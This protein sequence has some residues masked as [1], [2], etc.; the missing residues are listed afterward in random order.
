MSYSKFYDEI[1][2]IK[3]KDLLS[4]ILGIFKNGEYEFCY[5]DIVKSAGRSSPTIAVAYVMTLEALKELYPD[6][7]AL[8]GSIQV[9]FKDSLK[10]DMTGVIANV[11]SQITG[12]TSK[13]GF[14]GLDGNFAR[15]SL[16]FYDSDI[17][18]SVRFTRLEDF[19]SVDV[20]YD[21]SSITEDPLVYPLMQKVIHGNFTSEEFNKFKKLWQ[22]GIEKIFKN[23]EAVIS[24]KSNG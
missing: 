14:K 13:S 16:M 2:T 15:H 10:D 6:G 9:E 4:N 20:F 18:S 11:I 17:E 19:K 21:E 8:R 7:L 5:L 1:E 12:A 23:P 3:V 24:M 22:D